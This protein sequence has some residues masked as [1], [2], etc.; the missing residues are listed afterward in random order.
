MLG[1]LESATGRL[2]TLRD[3]FGE[4]FGEFDENDKQILKDNLISKNCCIFV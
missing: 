4:E 3:N 2:H 1:Q